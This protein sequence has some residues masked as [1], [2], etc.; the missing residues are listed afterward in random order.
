MAEGARLE[1]VYTFLRIEG[2]NPSLSA[3]LHFCLKTAGCEASQSD[4]RCYL[5]ATHQGFFTDR[6]GAQSHARRFEANLWVSI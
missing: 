3:K 1:S 5:Y 2:S 6:D 4:A